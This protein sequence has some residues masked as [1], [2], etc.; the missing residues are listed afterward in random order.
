MLTVSSTGI[1]GM[2]GWMELIYTC[3]VARSK[4]ILATRGGTV[5]AFII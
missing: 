2:D 3:Q 1:I 4:R 5:E